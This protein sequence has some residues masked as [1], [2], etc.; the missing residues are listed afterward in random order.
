MHFASMSLGI[1]DFLIEWLT[2][3]LI[4]LIGWVF[5]LIFLLFADLLFSVGTALLEIVDM[6]QLIFRKLSGLDTYW[7]VQ[8]SNSTKYEGVD[9]LLALMTNDDVIQILVT[10]TL[11]SVVMVI[12]AA[13]IKIIQ[14]EFS[15]EGAKNSKGAIFGT[16]LKSLLLFFLVP[17][18]CIGGVGISNALLKTIDRATNLSTG[19]AT[20]GSSIFV[21]AASNC[22][23]VRSGGNWAAGSNY[24]TSVGFTGEVNDTN[25]EAVADLIDMAFKDNTLEGGTLLAGVL[26]GTITGL[27]ESSVNLLNGLAKAQGSIVMPG[28]Y[29]YQSNGIVDMYYN[30]K[31]MNFITYI[32]AALLAAM[33]MLNVSFGMIMRLFNAV[34]L[35][36]IS[37]PV[38]ALMPLKSDAFT[39]WRRKFVGQVLA[40][41]GT[42]VALNLL[43]IILPVVDSIKLFAPL[44]GVGGSF[45][46][47]F[48]FNGINSFVSILFTLT[49]LF[50]IKDITK[51]I[52]EMVGAD[53]AAASGAGMAQKVGSTVGKIGAIGIGGVAGMAGKGVG[54][55]LTKMG[56]A[57]AGAAFG[58]MG[59][60]LFQNAKGTLGAAA[61]KGIGSIT[62][63][64]IKGKFSEETDYDK[65]MAAKDEK[66][67]AK[68]KRLE[69]GELTMGDYLGAKAKETGEAIGNSK[70]GQWNKKVFVDPVNKGRHAIQR[71]AGTVAA[72]TVGAVD[73]LITGNHGSKINKAKIEAGMYARDAWN[74]GKSGAVTGG[75]FDV[76]ELMG[77]G[78]AGQRKE[79]RTNAAG[80]QALDNAAKKLNDASQ[81]IIDALSGKGFDSGFSGLTSTQSLSQLEAMI[82]A[83]EGIE[84]KSDVQKD[85]LDR[86]TSAKGLAANG[87]SGNT[88]QEYLSSQTYGDS[89]VDLAGAIEGIRTEANAVVS[90]DIAVNVSGTVKTEQNVNDMAEKL[91]AAMNPT[92][93]KTSEGF[94]LLVEKMAKRLEESTKAELEKMKEE[95]K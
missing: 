14:S 32:G 74:G 37:P 70:W 44:G 60:K 72:G 33:T 62:G 34:I 46:A 65:A 6:I 23:R 13:I 41:Y 36:V 38:V 73:G 90:G 10:L 53:D 64:A 50:M 94:K 21:S 19:Q 12:V 80:N 58:N 81:A 56:H 30:I 16:A 28:Q 26:N 29:F 57:N 9:P 87:K 63:G 51:M 1:L 22:N 24:L 75:L 40:A 7:V 55:M 77:D 35:F 85:L 39:S 92:M 47:G 3:F 59:N 69:S 93:D 8:G 5:D 82:R 91:V 88:I 15:S 79:E 54:A 49:G 66:E 95:I 43:F 18:C 4:W 76:R 25:R 31:E 42:I 27:A 17:V 20:L 61:N 11:V 48:D 84:S 45:D 86:L 52:S 89:K 71:V 83:L 2:T 68:K 67:T 78:G